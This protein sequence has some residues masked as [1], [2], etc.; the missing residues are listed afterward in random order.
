MPTTQTLPLAQT[1]DPS[2]E[3]PCNQRQRVSVTA[4]CT[5]G[6]NSAKTRRNHKFLRTTAE[7]DAFTDACG[8]NRD[9]KQVNRGGRGSKRRQQ[10]ANREAACVCAAM[11]ECHTLSSAFSAAKTSA[12]HTNTCIRSIRVALWAL[13]RGVQAAGPSHPRTVGR[14][15]KG[16]SSAALRATLRRFFSVKT[17]DVKVCL[18][19]DNVCGCLGAR[20]PSNPSKRGEQ[21]ARDPGQTLRVWYWCSH[22]VFYGSGLAA[23]SMFVAQIDRTVTS[24]SKPPASQASS[25][26]SSSS[27]CT[28]MGPSSCWGAATSPSSTD[29]AA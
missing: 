8:Q 28:T 17:H 29:G 25:T 27:S 9:R 12:P 21:R 19:A 18:T 1:A 4:A 20:N 2:S 13:P 5:T 6:A 22:C 24:S 16:P 23:S 15:G 26:L 3:V 7:S 11:A 10:A 14:C